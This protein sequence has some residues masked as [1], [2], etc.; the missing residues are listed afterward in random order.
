MAKNIVIKEVLNSPLSMHPL[1]NKLRRVNKSW[2]TPPSPNVIAH[3]KNKT[4]QYTRHFASLSV[5]MLTGLQ[6]VKQETNFIVD[7]VYFFLTNLKYGT[8]RASWI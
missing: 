4:K 2:P 5:K 1:H 3:H 7:P 6:D 8:N